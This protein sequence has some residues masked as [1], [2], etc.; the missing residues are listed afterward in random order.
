MNKQTQFEM[1]QKEKDKAEKFNDY[2]AFTILN[3]RCCSHLR[4]VRS[5]SIPEVWILKE[6]HTEPIF[7]SG[8]TL[9]NSLTEKQN[10]TRAP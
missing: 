2:V 10:M 5:K 7:A 3:K 9:I 8:S 6:P 4:Y 1:Q